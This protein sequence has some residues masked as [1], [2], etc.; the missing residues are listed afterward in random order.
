MHKY[1]TYDIEALQ[2]LKFSS[3]NAQIESEE[4]FQYITGSAIRGAFIYKYI[5]NNRVD[6]INQGIHREKLL[7]GKIKFLNAYPEYDDNRSM[8]FPKCYFAPK[9]E[10]KTF[11][12]R[13][14]IKSCLDT[15][16]EQEYERVRLS[17]FVGY[18][19][20]NYYRVKVDK[21]SNLHINKLN[22]KNI[23]FRYESIKRGQIFKGI[24]KVEDDEY[25]EEV[26]D[27]FENAIVY[28]GGSKGSGYGKCLIKN[29]EVLEEN[30]EYKLVEDK[31]Y[32]E[33][34][35]YLI[36]MSDIIY[37]NE[38]GQYMTFIEPEYLAKELGLNKVEYVDSSIETKGITNFNNKWNCYSPHILGIK[39][40]SVFKYKIDGDIDIETLKAFMDKGIGE[41]KAEG[42]GRF[43]IVDSM[44]DTYLEE[45][46]EVKVD[47]Y[48]TFE[49]FS[50]L[51]E[52]EENQLQYIVDKIYENRLENYI[53]TIVIDIDKYMKNQEQINSSQWGKYKGLF[54]S[55]TYKEPEEGIESYKKYMNHI[56]QKRSESYRQIRKLK[57]KDK[58][59][60]DFLNDFVCNSTNIDLFYSKVKVDK[61]RLGKFES[62]IDKIFTYRYNM[63]ILAELFRYQIRKEGN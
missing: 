35:I 63:K 19:G 33:D 12:D 5:I 11:V 9:N 20:E 55:L 57:Y 18:D 61:V 45:S 2:D 4:T 24:I 8:P 22:E 7:K 58:D 44:E 50:N 3:T 51:N 37:R 41:R 53:S 48:D 60:L 15:S 17:E 6:D 1:L 46:S 10:I 27:L 56:V 32:F 39:A 62:K 47:D 43:I 36:A 26:K 49:L 16:L 38:V 13:I 21:N 30:P 40:G 59:F 23:L 34:E 54:S 28:L 14:S 52:D 31:D 25:V 29:I 42:Y